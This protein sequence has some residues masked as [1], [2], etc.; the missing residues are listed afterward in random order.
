LFDNVLHLDRTSFNA[1]ISLSFELWLFGIHNVHRHHHEAPALQ[2]R[3]TMDFHGHPSPYRSKIERSRVSV[4]TA[5]I[6]RSWYDHYILWL[7]QST[8]LMIKMYCASNPAE[9]LTL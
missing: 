3:S 4:S 2:Q 1:T 8:P 7:L 5:G 9:D 6:K